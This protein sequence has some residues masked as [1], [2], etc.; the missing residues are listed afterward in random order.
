MAPSHA[1]SPAM[2]TAT[3]WCFIFLK[4]WHVAHRATSFAN[5]TSDGPHTDSSTAIFT[6]CGSLLMCNQWTSELLLCGPCQPLRI[7]AAVSK[8]LHSLR[9]LSDWLYCCAASQKH[10]TNS[11]VHVN[12]MY[13]GT[14]LTWCH[15]LWQR[16]LAVCPSIQSLNSVKLDN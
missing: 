9:T 6:V 4:E 8:S 1:I 15:H 14:F 12:N 10:T 13:I 16:Q 5:S 3:G 11:N 2:T 7:K